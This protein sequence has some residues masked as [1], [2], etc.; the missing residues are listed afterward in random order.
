MNIRFAVLAADSALFTIRERMLYVRLIRVERPPHFPDNPG[1][2]GGLIAPQET[3]EEAARRHI[4]TKALV[5][6]DKPYVEQLYTFSDVGRDP[7][8]RVVAVAYLALVPWEKLT[9]EERRDTEDAYWAPVSSGASRGG[10]VARAKRL[11]YDHDE[12][13]ATALERLK[14]R[15]RYTTLIG[16][17]TPSEFTLTELEQSYECI[18]GKDLDKRNFRKKILKVKVL[19]ELAKKRSGGAFRPAKL[20]RFSSPNVDEIEVL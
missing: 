5:A 3:A 19:K 8:G 20:Y 12:I 6:A 9:D 2:P 4:E 18:L 15:V 16:K 7:R 13:L 11:A 14:S 1:L 17:L 10:P